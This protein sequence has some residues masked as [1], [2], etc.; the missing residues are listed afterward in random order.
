MGII[1]WYIYLVTLDLNAIARAVG[2]ECVVRG[3]PARHP[4]DGVARIGEYVVV[5]NPDFCTLL[6]GAPSDLLARLER[7]GES[8]VVLT[9]A[10][11]VSSADTP[12]LRELVAAYGVT[13]ILGS[14]IDGIA[15]HARLTA[16]LADDQAASDRL[17]TAGT[18]VLTQA[19]RRGGTDAVITELARR[20]DGWAVLLDINGHLIA[21]AGAGRLH[22][23]DAVAVALGRPVRVRHH[24]LQT[25]QVGSDRDLSGYLVIASRSSVTS[26]NRDL[27]SQAAA[28][29]DL[30]LR[31][32]DPSLTEH[33]GRVALLE[34][35]FA[36]GARAADLL[37]QWGVRE[38]SLTAFTLGSKTRTVD[39]ERL[40]TRW[41]DELGAEH[42]FVSEH[43]RVRGF[44]PDQLAGQ[45]SDLAAGFAPL[46]S[47]QVYLGLAAPMPVESLGR[48]A[49]QAK[50]A[51]EAA[52]AGGRAVQSYVEL[53]AVEFALKTMT[54]EQT[55]QLTGVLE[56]LREPNG[57]HGVLTDTLQIFLVQNSAHR[58]S[59][60]QLGIHR[61]TLLSRIR[62]VEDL[63]GLSMDLPDD[64]TAAW[65][66]LRALGR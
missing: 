66:A 10:A 50:Q 3:V 51:V 33:L 27:A 31:K 60:A 15:L 9:Q 30:L 64:R 43:G 59:A 2:G 16:V 26:R 4:I 13:A 54:D 40:I 48:G 14:D 11:F 8:A 63:T 29:F 38:S 6:T 1:I 58:A 34:T 21:S 20:L 53:P 52:L 36:G 61:Q 5:G 18:R 47:G 24:G 39:L 28:L 35:L 7:G 37:L 55:Q 57:E 42:V 49:I 17:V 65:L 25:H 32:R 45:L 44:V 46:G 62:R 41:L 22:I 12:E 23:E 56:A 19:A